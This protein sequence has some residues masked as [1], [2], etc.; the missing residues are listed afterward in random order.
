MTPPRTEAHG[1]R[2][3][4]F[5]RALRPGAVDRR[6]RLSGVGRAASAGRR[7]AGG[8]TPGVR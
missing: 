1:G 5:G 4:D 7:T 6:L 2:L 8:R 3:A